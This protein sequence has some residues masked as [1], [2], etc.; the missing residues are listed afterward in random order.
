MP[1]D[2]GGDDV[3]S[4]VDCSAN[5]YDFRGHLLCHDD[6]IGT[7]SVSYILYLTHPDETWLESDGGGLELFPMTGDGEDAMP[8]NDPVKVLLPNFGSMALF[9]VLPGRSFH[10]VGEVLSQGKPRLSISG[11]FHEKDAPEDAGRASRMQLITPARAPMPGADAEG[12]DPERSQDAKGKG[13]V[14]EEELDDVMRIEQRWAGAHKLPSLPGYIGEADIAYLRGWVS[15]EYLKH[16]VVSTLRTKFEEEACFHLHKFLNE[17][18]YKAIENALR[19]ESEA[20]VPPAGAVGGWTVVGPPHKQR[21]EVYGDSKGKKG[22]GMGPLLQEC[23]DELFRAD[24][25]RR[26]LSTITGFDF[27]YAAGTCRC[28]AGDTPPASLR[29]HTHIRASAFVWFRCEFA[30]RSFVVS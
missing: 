27:T 7:R 23:L 19:L 13:A 25:F 24:S 8:A 1:L 22:D 4:Q 20:N 3:T 2:D 17:D 15:E 6:V 28:V 16:D 29:T 30:Q 10:S 18:R 14:E 5:V 21:F 26:W 9:K 11:W 12:S